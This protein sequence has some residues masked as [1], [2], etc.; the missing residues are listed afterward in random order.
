MGG[1]EGSLATPT[2]GASMLS[3]AAVMLS[4]QVLTTGR[5]LRWELEKLEMISLNWL[6]R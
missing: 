4:R 6:I 5:T 2:L 1:K 3:E